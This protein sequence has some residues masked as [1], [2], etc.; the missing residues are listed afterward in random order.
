LKLC[1]HQWD[2]RPRIQWE[3]P[4]GIHGAYVFFGP[5]L[6]LPRRAFQ[7]GLMFSKIARG[8]DW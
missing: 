2:Q 1:N 4:W 6:F 5:F 3:Y 8:C 7:R